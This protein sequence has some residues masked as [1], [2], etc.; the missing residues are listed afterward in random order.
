MVRATTTAAISAAT[1]IAAPATSGTPS[2]RRRLTG[3]ESTKASTMAITTGAS[4]GSASFRKRTSAM[5]NRPLTCQATGP[6]PIDWSFISTLKTL[7]ILMERYG[8]RRSSFHAQ[9]R[10]AAAPR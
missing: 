4:T 2:R 1:V 5:M 7:E 8:V 6:R 3:V 10:A 9:F